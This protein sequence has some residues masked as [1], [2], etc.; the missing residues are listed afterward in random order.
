MGV[1]A[2]APFFVKLS[3]MVYLHKNQS[4]FFIK[5]PE[6]THCQYIK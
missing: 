3:F 4:T 2:T 5:I 6:K 1:H